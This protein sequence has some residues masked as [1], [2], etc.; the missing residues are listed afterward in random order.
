MKKI[1]L[2]FVFLSLSLSA[3]KI[4]SSRWSDLFS[5]NNIIAIRE[6]EGKLFAATENG[7]F[8][9][10]ITSGEESKLSKANGLHEVKISAFD[11]N[12]AT[13]TGLVGYQNG[14]LDV[15]TPEG[16]T[17]I[18]DIPI[19]TG[20]QGNK[21]INHISINGNLAAISSGYGVSVFNLESK[22]F[23]ESAF[24]NTGG[25][26]EASLEAVI[27]DNTVFAITAAGNILSHAIDDV[28]FPVYS[29]WNTVAS[30]GFR[31][32]A[33]NGIMVSAT[34]TTVNYGTGS[35]SGFLDIKDVVLTGEHIIVSE[36]KKIS[37][38]AQSGT[39]VRTFSLADSINTGYFIDNKIFAGTK[40]KGILNE[41]RKEI[42]PKGPY[43]NRSYK[44]DLVD[45]QI[46]ISSGG[47]DGYNTAVYNNLGFYR[48]DGSEWHY[49]D[50]FL[51]Q[52]ELNVLDAVANPSDPNEIFFVNFAPGK[53]SK[54]V[55]RLTGASLVK[56]PNLNNSN[57]WLYEPVGLAFDQNSQ[58]F[59]TYQNVEQQG[60]NL[61]KA[62]VAH[63]NVSANNFK[64]LNIFN[65]SSAQKPL[66]R[67]NHIYI[68]Q[69]YFNDG[70]LVIYNYR[71]TPS[72][73][74]DDAYATINDKN[75]LP[76]KGVISVA[77]DKN[78]DAWIGTRLGLRV[79]QN[80]TAAVSNPGVQTD[81]IVIEENG[82]GE[83]LFRDNNILQIEVDAGNQK[84]VS[85][86]GGGVFYLSADGER[87]ISHF[88]KA[89]S[90]LPTDNVTD[91]KVDKR[92][93]KV[94][95]V[96]F[97]GVVVYQG[98]VV[99]VSENFAN[100][101]VYPNPVVHANYKGNVRIRGL[102][103][104]TNIRITDSAGNLVHQ[105]VS[106]GGYYEWDLNNQRGIRVASGIYFVLMTNENGTDTAT[107]KIAVVN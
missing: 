15:I 28:T 97:D 2:L 93:G 105:A 69:P 33:Q 20:F 14:T 17:F 63:Y 57:W 62:A 6:S 3:Q 91:V 10:D 34:D 21:R 72:S 27:H 103:E 18:V 44:I 53:A 77:I 88:T 12:P 42:K 30:G 89:N 81:P 96:T 11:Y 8:Y 46:L 36:P 22:E 26:F 48:F 87:T 85:V 13:K 1:V 50:F 68:P 84:W 25:T 83:E 16:I 79:L 101:L 40:F 5:Y 7:L 61:S 43:N 4:S 74:G 70:G 71:G 52:T 95:F 49:P 32:L 106:R 9:Y 23:G 45:D 41:S 60:N 19:A 31:H 94:Y 98:D 75:N 92:N 99:D 78:E 29:T 47:R 90:P 100:V 39:P 104:K 107:A 59:A 102:A 35:L 67:D 37:V 24:F 54:G 38:F 58:L 66:I 65:T 56:I 82:V 55:Y 51:N 76:T 86:E 73:S 80:P 64:V